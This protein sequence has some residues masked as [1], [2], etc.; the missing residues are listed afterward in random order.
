MVKKRDSTK[1]SED[2]KVQIRTSQLRTRSASQ[3]T[4]KESR[5]GS[6]VDRGTKGGKTKR[7]AIYPQPKLPSKLEVGFRSVKVMQ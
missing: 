3:I 1:R 4:V 7:L 2:I 6:A 5:K